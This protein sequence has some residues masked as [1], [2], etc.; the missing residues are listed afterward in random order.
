MSA[1]SS[2]T[3]MRT[4][5]TVLATGPS[6]GL[7]IWPAGGLGLGWAS[8]VTQVSLPIPSRDPSGCR[9]PHE[10]RVLTYSNTCRL[11]HTMDSYLVITAYCQ[12]VSYTHLTLPT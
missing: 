2:A 5:V 10:L 12:S 6:R 8:S 11:R 3:R 1:S 9:D 4:L 7:S